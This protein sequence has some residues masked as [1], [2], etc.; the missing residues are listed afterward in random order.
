MHI[1]RQ[2]YGLSATACS[3]YIWSSPRI[4]K[5]LINHQHKGHCVTLEQWNYRLFV[6]PL[7]LV[8]INCLNWSLNCSNVHG[9]MNT[10]LH[11][12][13]SDVLTY[14]GYAACNLI[15][16]YQYLCW[17]LYFVMLYPTC[18][19]LSMLWRSMCSMFG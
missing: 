5:L 3:F 11:L 15:L 6:L 4:L 12:C 8:L 19:R 14:L 9:N 2:D 18:Y 10:T 16:L 13:T 17:P 7:A 1:S